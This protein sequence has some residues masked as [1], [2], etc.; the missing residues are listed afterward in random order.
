MRHFKMTLRCLPAV[1]QLSRRGLWRH[2]HMR[3]NWRYKC[4]FAYWLLS[5]ESATMA[6]LAGNGAVDKIRDF[7]SADSKVEKI[8]RLSLKVLQNFVKSGSLDEDMGTRDILEKVKALD[9]EKWNEAALYDQIHE[10]SQA[11][12]STVSK[13]SNF[14]RYRKELL[15]KELKPGPL[16]TPSFWAHPD[17]HKGLDKEVIKQL[18]ELVNSANSEATLAIAC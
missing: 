10:V 6:K 5:F 17:T 14:D 18:V 7:L 11:I 3:L 8:V 13:V 16:H 15:T 1:L 2:R 9:Y 12:A 4:V